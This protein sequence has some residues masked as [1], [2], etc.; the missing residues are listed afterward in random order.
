MYLEDGQALNIGADIY[1]RDIDSNISSVTVFAT[2]KSCFSGHAEQRHDYNSLL[3]LLIVIHV[4]AFIL[5][6]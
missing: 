3:L 2:G 1:L 6:K 5:H 4:S